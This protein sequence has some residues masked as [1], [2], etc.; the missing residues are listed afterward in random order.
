[1]LRQS[2]TF[3]AAHI[4][5]LRLNNRAAFATRS[6]M[7]RHV[8]SE[9]SIMH[10]AFSSVAAIFRNVYR[11]SFEFDQIIRIWLGPKLVV[12]LMDPRDVEIVLSSHVYLDKSTEYHF[13]KPWLGNGLL[14]STGEC[15][16]FSI[17][18]SHRTR[19]SRRRKKEREKG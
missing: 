15:C 14:I 7:W 8:T 5:V 12:F 18:D 19:F 10:S 4:H 16:T 17:R 11:K 13:F 9:R 6:R 3:F 1:M 2:S